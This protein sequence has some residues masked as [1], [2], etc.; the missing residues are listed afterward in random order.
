M[1]IKDLQSKTK[2]FLR[3]ALKSYT[4]E[5][6]DFESFMPLNVMEEL[7]LINNELNKK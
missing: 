4:E 6:K 1:N 2:L 5:H 7:N 3:L